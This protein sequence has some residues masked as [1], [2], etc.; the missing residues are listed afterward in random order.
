MLVRPFVQR[1]GLIGDVHGA[2]PELE[3]ALAHFDRVGVDA[4][5]AVGDYVDAPAFAEPDFDG[6]LSLLREAGAFCVRGNHDRWAL[7]HKRRLWPGC[8]LK[9]ELSEESQAF[10]EGLPTTIK[11]RTVHGE[12]LLCHGLGTDDMSVLRNDTPLLTALH[13]PSLAR[14]IRDGPRFVLCGHTH[15]HM[16]R[17]FGELTV[18]NAGALTLSHAPGF[19]LIDFEAGH[20]E[21]HAFGAPQDAPAQVSSLRCVIKRPSS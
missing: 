21:F 4:V 17:D 9:A 3:Q 1:L 5:A 16:V 20:V 12:A 6:C 7:T 13:I 15:K 8:V 18:I 10:L 14:L 19:T 11:F 2:R